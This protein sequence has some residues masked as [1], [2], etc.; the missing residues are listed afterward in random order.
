MTSIISVGPIPKDQLV[1]FCVYVDSPKRLVDASAA[2]YYNNLGCI[3]MMMRKH[4]LGSFYFK[5]ALTENENLSKELKLETLGKDSL[6]LISYLM[7]GY[8]LLYD[9][10]CFTEM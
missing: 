9:N 8:I 3:H 7:D 5:K 1:T 2:M 6:W 10:D 4:T